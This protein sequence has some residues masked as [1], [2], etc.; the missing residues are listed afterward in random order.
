MKVA[1]KLR[2]ESIAGYLIYM[3][4]VEDLMRAFDLDIDRVDKE[5]LIRFDGQ[6]DDEHQE[7]RKWYNDI[8][9]MMRSEGVAR[10]GHLQICRNVIINLSE[11]HEKLMQ[12]H[13]YPYYHSAY[14]KALPLIVE[15]RAKQGDTNNHPELESCFDLLYGVTLLKMQGREIS[16]DTAKAVDTIS[17]F[18]GCLSDY[19]HKD[20]EEK[21]EF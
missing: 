16:E 12:S 13:K 17:T 5:Y 3:W 18:I 7:L 9:E 8:I 20:K 11:L 21:L 2:K 6:S 15:L 4:Q 14:Q 19:Y 10:K 1:E